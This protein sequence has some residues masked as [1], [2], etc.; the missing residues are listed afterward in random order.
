[1][2]GRL[3]DFDMEN[4]GYRHRTMVRDAQVKVAE[5]DPRGT[6]V[7][8][9]ELNNKGVPGKENNDLHYTKDGYKVLGERFAEKAI[10]LIK[11]K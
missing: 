11:R 7:N 8:M 4:K 6:W 9:D 1:M 3:S 10:E 5:A 2:I